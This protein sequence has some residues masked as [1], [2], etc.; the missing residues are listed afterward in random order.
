MLA[1]TLCALLSAAES[2]G[3][4]RIKLAVLSLKTDEA[5]AALGATIVDLSSSRLDREGVFQ[6]IT[7]DDVKQMVNFDQMKTALSCD[8]QASCLAEI[9]QALGV[10]Y[11]MT[12]TLAQVG[13]RHV[14]TMVLIDI[15]NARPL[16]RESASYATVEE[17]MGGL[18]KQ[19]ERTVA[20]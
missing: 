17:L 4:N 6:V 16:K 10:S 9:G 15:Q 1:I 14:L 2:D 5:S 7:E 13:G 20:V 12:G 19:V 11:I 8:E 18:D 3:D